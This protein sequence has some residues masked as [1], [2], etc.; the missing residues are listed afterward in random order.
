MNEPHEHRVEPAFP[1]DP[2][3][4]RD[5]DDEALAALWERC[6][7]GALSHAEREAFAKWLQ[8]NPRA[9]EAFEAESRWLDD[10]SAP[11]PDVEADAAAFT[12]QTLQRWDRERA[13]DRE[14]ER[15]TTPILARLPWRWAGLAACVALIG[16]TILLTL[17]GPTTGPPPTTTLPPETAGPPAEGDLHGEAEP[18]PLTIIVADM[19]DVAV[20]SRTIRE[21]IERGR[22][23]WNVDASLSRLQPSARRMV[24]ADGESAWFAGAAEGLGAFDVERLGRWVWPSPAMAPQDGDEG[25]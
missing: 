9:A 16:V 13:H 11:E 15:G 14:R 5:G 20:H 22:N 17:Q 25:R 23:F 21:G 3:A 24:G 1:G 19:R 8:D 7:D 12:E 18:S 6:R 2:A 4:G 10:L